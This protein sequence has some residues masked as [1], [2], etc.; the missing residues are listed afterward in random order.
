MV[1]CLMRQL[2]RRQV[3]CALTCG[4]LSAVS[5]RATAQSNSPNPGVDL[6]VEGRVE[7][8]F[9]DGDDLLVQIMVQAAE[10]T[11]VNPAAAIRYPALGQYVY[12]HVDADSVRGGVVPG[13]RP[14]APNPDSL[15][16]ARLAAG[17][18]G[19]WVSSGRDWFDE[20]PQAGRT[21]GRPPRGQSGAQAI[22]LGI[23]AERVFVGGESGLKVTRVSPQSPAAQ[24]GIEPGDVLM[25]AAG[26]ALESQAQL[27]NAF[28]SSRG[29]L[30]VTVR[31]VRTGRELPVEIESGGI[32]AGRDIPGGR[33]LGVVT[34]TAFY[35]GEAALKVT[36]VEAN[37][38]AQQAAIAPGLLILKVNG[39]SVGKP[40]ELSDAVRRVRGQIELLVVDPQDRRE[41]TVRVRL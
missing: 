30:V 20:D 25:T 14:A 5:L 19:R 18:S 11:L 9:R 28:R 32:S 31:D 39:R 15:I 23:E 13:R 34:E 36:Q 40:E 8:V 41:R 27:E 24:A 22:A 6:V 10:A 26:T 3:I 4:V 38:P 29:A 37:S 1:D 7:R 35:G 16:R 21:V 12:V 17:D 2:R 33:S